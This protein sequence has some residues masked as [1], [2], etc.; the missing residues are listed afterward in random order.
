MLTWICLS[1]RTIAKG[2][3]LGLVLALLLLALTPQ[4]RDTYTVSGT[5][6]HCTSGTKIAEATVYAISS[7]GDTTVTVSD[8]SGLYLFPSLTGGQDYV[9]K[10]EKSG[11]FRWAVSSWDGL[12]LLQHLTL[13]GFYVTPCQMLAGHGGWH[14]LTNEIFDFVWGL[15]L[16]PGADVGHW[17]FIPHDFTLTEDNFR[18]APDSILIEALGAD[19]TGQGF[20]AVLK[21]DVSSNWGSEFEAPTAFFSTTYHEHHDDTLLVQI[22]LDSTGIDPAFVTAELFFN[23]DS[24]ALSFAESD[25]TEGLFADFPGTGHRHLGNGRLHCMGMGDT[26]SGHG[27]AFSLL[28]TF[29]EGYDFGTNSNWMTICST[30][31]E[32][33]AFVFYSCCRGI[34]GN[35]DN[36]TGP[37]GDIDVSD[38]TYLVAYL[39]SGGDEPPCIDE[40][41][42]DGLLGPAG[43]IDVSDLTYLVAYLFNGGTAP[44][45]CP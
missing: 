8:S 12:L 45:T 11:G 26:L 29:A 16:D 9:I 21:G 32:E 43:P 4:A 3:W 42:I 6:E 33:E 31:V 36:H 20:Y 2:T 22:N 24:S 27:H 13:P 39:F 28:F 30:R 1:L 38:L 7:A 18:D 23:Y 15:D 37:A 5:L 10:P 34:R 41:N 17:Q 19:Q 35:T 25:F 14:W 40:G 44:P